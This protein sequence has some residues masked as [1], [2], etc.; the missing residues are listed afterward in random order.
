MDASFNG[1]LT[2]SP[3]HTDAVGGRPPHHPFTPIFGRACERLEW[4]IFAHMP[5]LGRQLLK[6]VGALVLA[7]DSVVHE[8]QPVG[9]VFVFDLPRR[10]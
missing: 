9:V 1:S 8:E 2:P 4:G 7:A 3:W 10:G 5:H 6:S